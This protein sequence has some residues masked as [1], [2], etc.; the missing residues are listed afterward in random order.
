[1]LSSLENRRRATVLGTVLFASL[2]GR[3]ASAADATGGVV[4]TGATVAAPGAATKPAKKSDEKSDDKAGAAPEGSQADTDVVADEWFQKARPTFE[5]HGYYRL[6][7]ELFASFSLGR[8]DSAAKSFW[9]RPASDSYVDADG[10]AND[11]NVCGDAPSNPEP[12]H[13]SVQAGANMR[14]RLEP[15]IVISDNLR[16]VAQLDLLDNL[17]LGSTP[18][19]Y[20]NVPSESGGYGVRQRGGY[21]PIGAFSATQWAPI[22]GQ[23]SLTDSIVVKRAFGEYVSPVG[24]FRFGRMPNHWGLGMLYNAGDGRDSDWSSTADRIQFSTGF[25]SVDL[26]FGGQWDFADEGAQAAP[27][28]TCTSA[29]SCGQGNL[30]GRRYDLVQTDDIDQIGLFVMHKRHADRAK[31]DLAKGDAVINAGFYGVYRSQY[32]ESSAPL[33]ASPRDV[34]ETFVRRGYESVTSDAWGQF[35]WKKLRVEAEAAVIW[36]GI[37]NTDTQGG[38]NFDNPGGEDGDDGWHIRQFGFALETEWK[39]IEDRLHFNFGFGFA[40]GDDDVEGINGLGGRTAALG[41]LDDQLTKDRTFSTFRFHPDYRVDLILWRNI[42]QRVQAAYYFRPSVD[43]D[44][45][46]K[47]D[48][49]RLGGGLAF[50]WSRATDPVQTPGNAPDLGLEIDVSVRYQAPFG[51]LSNDG[52]MTGFFTALEYGVLFP[53][54]GLG[55]LPA[56]EARLKSIGDGDTTLAFPETVRWYAGIFF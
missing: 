30:E 1:M 31:L 2:I 20:V 15:S 22:A 45:I 37:E 14:L 5:L 48:G 55:Y 41:G 6:R 43:Y 21:V 34:T 32:L 53:L 13:S 23:N 40:T 25:P 47:T 33:A 54:P 39:A 44:F 9:P 56:E 16:A 29:E 26:Y 7:S 17:V 46:K 8:R 10:V 19:G 36:G 12:C 28:L 18:D 52:T 11:V 42:L 4:P 27:Y 51:S 24:T 49:Q 38:N 50:V 35:F 3:E